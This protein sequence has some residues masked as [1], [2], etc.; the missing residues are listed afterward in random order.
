MLLQ[1]VTFET[2]HCNSYDTKQKIQL[3][4]YGNFQENIQK[5]TGFIHSLVET[6]TTDQILCG[7]LNIVECG[8]SDEKVWLVMITTREVF[9]TMN[10]KYIFTSETFCCW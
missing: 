5:R 8:H 7:M 1:P 6:V 9:F 10:L 2:P 4:A 3:G